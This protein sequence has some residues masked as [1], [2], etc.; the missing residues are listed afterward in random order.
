[1]YDTQLG[2]HHVRLGFH[3]IRCIFCIL[4]NFSNTTSAAH[5]ASCLRLVLFLLFTPP[6]SG[7]RAGFALVSSLPPHENF[8]WISL[9][10]PT[11]LQDRFSASRLSFWLPTSVPKVSVAKSFSKLLPSTGRLLLQAELAGNCIDSLS[12]SLTTAFPSSHSLADTLF[13]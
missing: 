6:N 7:I 3:Y 2:F 13:G 1:M 4:H 9:L 5:F 10:L 12:W 8:V 11:F